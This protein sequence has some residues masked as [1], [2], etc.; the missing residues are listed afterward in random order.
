MLWGGCWLCCLG[1]LAA[2]WAMIP[3]SGPRGPLPASPFLLT[4]LLSE[5]SDPQ[6]DSI[7]HWWIASLVLYLAALCYGLIQMIGIYW[8]S[9]RPIAMLPCFAVLLVLP[10]HFFILVLGAPHPHIT[11][12]YWLAMLVPL[13]GI[14][15]CFWQPKSARVSN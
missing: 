11:M 5:I 6:T 14:E 12:Y 2:P 13:L 7:T 1:L 10:V 8:R 3:A 9:P 4:A 15:F